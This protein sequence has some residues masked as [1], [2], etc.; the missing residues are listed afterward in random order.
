MIHCNAIV[1]L[2]WA[3]QGSKRQIYKVT[4]VEKPPGLA[5]RS[6]TI[7]AESDNIAAKDGIERFT[8]EFSSKDEG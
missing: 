2:I 5:T 1:D 3:P 6:Y 7:T 8:G 4:V